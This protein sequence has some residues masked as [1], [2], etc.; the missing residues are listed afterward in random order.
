M[1]CLTDCHRL[2]RVLTGLK[3]DM[4]LIG[5]LTGGMYVDDCLN[6]HPD[7]IQEH[8]G[9]TNQEEPA[10]QRQSGAGHSPDDPSSEEDETTDKTDIDSNSSSSL[11]STS[12]DDDK[13]EWFGIEQ[14]DDE[15]SS[16]SDFN[17]DSEWSDV[18][19]DLGAAESGPV[20][21]SEEIQDEIIEEIIEN[22]EH[23][24][25]HEAV[26]VPKYPHPLRRFSLD[27]QSSFH[28][29]LQAVI[30][31]GEGFPTPRNFGLHADE[32]EGEGYRPY[33]FIRSGRRGG[34]RELRIELPDAIWR[35]RAELW[36]KAV[37]LLDDV[38]ANAA[39]ESSSEDVS[40]E[41]VDS[42][43]D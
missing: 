26:H 17:S 2:N 10:R 37:S 34:N 1:W 7:I 41:S 9:V 43:S 13:P 36:A 8:Y 24:F 25:L 20:E 40:M 39:S 28:E 6:V 32:W 23:N 35:P 16:E 5:M 31:D 14:Q 18:I 11:S 27:V 3:Q 21:A 29:A 38:L 4:R 42:D 15:G 12:D 33:E 22:T 19:D 30:D